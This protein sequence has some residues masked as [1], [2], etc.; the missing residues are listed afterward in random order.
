MNRFRMK[1]DPS[2]LY[3]VTSQKHPAEGD[4]L[5]LA[6]CFIRKGIRI[7]YRLAYLDRNL[8][9]QEAEAKQG[10]KLTGLF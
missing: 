9:E 7:I 8:P 2:T 1:C 3:G 6:W 5:G 4:A 10:L